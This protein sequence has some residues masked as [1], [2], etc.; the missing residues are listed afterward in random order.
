MPSL[1]LLLLLIAG[2][3]NS[4]SDFST[5]VKSGV[6]LPTSVMVS[7][8]CE[9]INGALPWRPRELQLE[10]HW[11]RLSCATATASASAAA[12]AGGVA[13]VRGNAKAGTGTL[14]AGDDDAACLL[15]LLLLVCKQA[16]AIFS[17]QLQHQP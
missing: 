10:K 9:D 14:V 3:T 7:L 15:L 16:N 12:K 13:E 4:T 5:Q 17:L 2:R 6:R 1:S 11:L 8:N